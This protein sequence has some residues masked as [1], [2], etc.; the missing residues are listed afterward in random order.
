MTIGTNE[1]DRN[2]HREYCKAN[3]RAWSKAVATIL[4]V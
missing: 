4:T 1:I 2:T 3:K